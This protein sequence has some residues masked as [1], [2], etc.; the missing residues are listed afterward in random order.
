MTLPF[1]WPARLLAVGALAALG[2]CWTTTA[3]PV[4]IRTVSNRPDLVSGGDVL[5]ELVLPATAAGLSVKV[6]GRDV[7]SAFAM[8][9]GGRMLGLVSG[10]NVGTNVITALA[11][12]ADVGTLTVTN[13][14]RHGPVLSGAQITPY[15]CATPA[16]LATSGNAPATNASGLAGTP[17]AN[18]NIA[19]EYKLYYRTTTAGCSL[20]LPDPSPSVSATAAAPAT[21]ANPPAN[22]CF[23]PYTAGVTP[24]DLATT[25]TDAGT[26]VPYI[27]RV[28][29]GT[30]N[31]G[32]YD[33]AVLW[34]GT[35]S[36]WDPLAPH[37]AWNTRWCSTLAPAPA[38][39]GARR[40]RR[41]PGRAAT[42][43]SAK[44]RWWWPTA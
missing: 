9:S 17:D 22:P 3:D 2:G 4:E 36:S 15:F 37:A 43:N 6:N 23:K 19:T 29:R 18:C 44:A 5:V 42:C 1:A 31:R 16:P 38:S 34:D 20:A 33:I 10:L 14:P 21:T 39:R 13:A 7:T 26:S 11:D 24:G 12:S 25:T 8:S 27:V 28:E 30:M 35:K 32:I 40:G 41:R